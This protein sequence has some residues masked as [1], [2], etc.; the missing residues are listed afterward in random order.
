MWL[1]STMGFGLRGSQEHRSMCWGD[2]HLETDHEGHE[3]LSFNERQTKTRQGDTTDTR[4]I[5]PKLWANVKN[6]ARC[7]IEV[8][9]TYCVKRPGNFSNEDDPFYIATSTHFRSTETERWFIRQPIGQ[10]KLHNIMKNMAKT[11]G[12]SA[13]RLTNH[14]ARKTMLQKLVDKDVAPTDIMQ[15]SGH[16]NIQSVFNYSKMNVNNHKKS[17]I[18][19]L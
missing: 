19:N 15:I 13:I 7:P 12:G 17:L 5:Q 2:V 10:N 6:K 4:K 8:Y 18:T 9:K 1:Y 3:F 11:L 14:S 16:K